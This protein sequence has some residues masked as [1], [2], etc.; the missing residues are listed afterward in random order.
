MIGQIL[1]S[2]KSW[3]WVSAF[4]LFSCFIYFQ[5]TQEKKGLIGELKARIQEMKIEKEK[6]QELREDL[7][8]SVASQ[9]DPAWVEMVLMRDL[10]V[11]P[12]G[13]LKVH[14]KKASTNLSE[15]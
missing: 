6:A 11:V 12:E 4:A 3:W 5:S 9:D 8:L 7:L 2:W 15:P 13:W 1:F 14:F 10:G